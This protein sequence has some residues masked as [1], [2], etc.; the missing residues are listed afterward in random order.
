MW[1]SLK[2]DDIYGPVNDNFLNSGL[3]KKKK[4]VQIWYYHA[5]SSCSKKKRLVR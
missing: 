2:I 3:K 1:K 5:I 4:T